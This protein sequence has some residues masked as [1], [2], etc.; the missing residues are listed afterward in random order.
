VGYIESASGFKLKLPNFDEF[1]KM[2]FTIAD[3]S[4]EFWEK[5]RSGKEQYQE[6]V[7]IFEHNLKNED[8][9]PPYKIENHDDYN[10]Y[11]EYKQ[12]VS[13]YFKLRSQYMRLCLN[14][15]IQTTAA[16]QTKLAVT[17]LFEYIIKKGH[18]WK[19]RISNVPHDEILLEVTDDLVPEYCDILGRIMRYAGDQYM[20]SGIIKM[21]ADAAAGDSWYSAKK[22]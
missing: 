10:L 21:K 15:P 16:H 9:L 11:M 19:V 18:Q 17:L 20:T 12:Y 4:K 2:A 5:Y 8:K 1:Q 7:R 13:K 3:F 14:N 22:G 6:K